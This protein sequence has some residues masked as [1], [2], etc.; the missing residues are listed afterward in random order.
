MSTGLGTLV[1]KCAKIWR[2]S[3]GFLPNSPGP[4]LLKAV[5]WDSVDRGYSWNLSLARTW[6][7]LGLVFNI[8]LDHLY[9]TARVSNSEHNSR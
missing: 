4:M 2:S 7:M 9:H 5:P 3:A 1:Q 6:K 8:A